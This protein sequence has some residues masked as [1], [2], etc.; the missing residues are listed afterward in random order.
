MIESEG[1]TLEKKS[2]DNCNLKKKRIL[3]VRDHSQKARYY[4]AMRWN[5]RVTSGRCYDRGRLF[6]T[7]GQQARKDMI[8]CGVTQLGLEYG[9]SRRTKLI[10][11]REGGK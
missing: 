11:R 6:K 3:F 8:L 10:G 4:C 2:M 9:L 1:S 7:Q 5:Q